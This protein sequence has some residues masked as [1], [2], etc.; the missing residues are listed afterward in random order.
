MSE[1]TKERDE[2]EAKKK[3]E[4]KEYEESRYDEKDSQQDEFLKFLRNF[5]HKQRQEI[6]TMQNISSADQRRYEGMI[7]GQKRKEWDAEKDSRTD[8]GTTLSFGDILKKTQ[9][10]TLRELES[11]AKG[12]GPLVRNFK[13]SGMTFDETVDKILDLTQHR[14]H[15]DDIED[16]IEDM[17]SAEDRYWDCC[18]NTMENIWLLA[19]LREITK[20]DGGA[21]EKH[22]LVSKLQPSVAGPFKRA[23]INHIH[24]GQSKPALDLQSQTD[25]DKSGY[26]R[27]GKGGASDSE[28]DNIFLREGPQGGHPDHI[29]IGNFYWAIVDDELRITGR[30]QTQD[31]QI[32]SNLPKVMQAIMKKVL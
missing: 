28:F 8:A 22:I 9:E 21:P 19:R 31:K 1:Y 32:I 14:Y 24:I 3:A 23:G 18:E 26:K 5:N 15:R 25:I 12:F 29:H 13:S 27:Y 6:Y 4:D 7:H 10:S 11:K 16:D 20:F 2:R 17:W 30:T